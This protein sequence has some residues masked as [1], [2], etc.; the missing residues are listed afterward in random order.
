MYRFITLLTG[1]KVIKNILDNYFGFNKQQ[2]R[3]LLVLCSICLALTVIR[4][5]YPYFIDKGPI[6]VQNL[7]L[8]ERKLD[9]AEQN[10]SYSKKYNNAENPKGKLFVFDPNTISYAELLTLGFKEKTAGIFVKFRN[11]G[12]VFKQK[13]DLKKVYGIT[14]NFYDRLE[15][16]ILLKNNFAENKTKPEASSETLIAVKT[17]T[18]P[19]KI[20]ELNGADSLALLEINGIGPAFAKRILKYRGLLGGFIKPEQLKEVYGFTEEMY[21]KIRTQVSVNAS[22][23][24]KINLR[25]DDFKAINKH[26]YLSYEL[27]KSIFD[28]KRKTNITKDNLGGILND[29]LLLQKLLPYLE[30]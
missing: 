14:D 13:Q 16:Y 6:N 12:F 1:K 24:K 15:P 8:I 18:A 23:I 21:D 10:N 4:L 28:F 5:G 20:T 22:F 11:K 7:P 30:F 27:T 29:E 25:K 26:P 3:G 9:S 19:N 2:R 17:K